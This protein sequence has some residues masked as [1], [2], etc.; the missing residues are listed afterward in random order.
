MN[1]HNRKKDG[2]RLKNMKLDLNDNELQIVK[3][4]GI[5]TGSWR[6]LTAFIIIVLAT[7]FILW[8]ITTNPAWIMTICNW[9]PLQ[10]M[11]L[12]IRSLLKLLTGFVTMR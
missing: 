8:C 7:I 4:H 9:E 6:T 1:K 11:I 5:L 2:F 12:I 3:H 10:Y